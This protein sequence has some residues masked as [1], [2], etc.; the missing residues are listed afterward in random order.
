[1]ELSHALNGDLLEDYLHEAINHLPVPSAFGLFLWELLEQRALHETKL[2]GVSLLP[3]LVCQACGGNASDATSVTA[4]WLLVRL[5]AK[6]LDDIEDGQCGNTTGPLANAAVAMLSLAQVVLQRV[7]PQLSKAQTWRLGTSLQRAL[8]RAAGGQ[9]VDLTVSREPSFDGPSPDAWLRVASAKTG[10]LLAWAAAAGAI[11]ASAPNS[12]VTAYQA[13]GRYLGVLLQLADDFN[14][15]WLEEPP[16]DLTNGCLNLAP[17]YAVWVGSP[18][19]VRLLHD[20]LQEAKTNH[21]GALSDIRELLIDMGAQ[22]Y[23]VSVAQLHRQRAIA[24]LQRATPCSMQATTA[25]RELVERTFPDPLARG[26][27]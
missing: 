5:S 14:D 25:L 3:T 10:A 16:N 13:Y 15:A 22:A 17:C 21:A 23:F 20:R 7:P 24:A 4:A 9:H 6:M 12:V 8:L 18:E 19:E 11:A 27:G 2:E 26:V 1:M